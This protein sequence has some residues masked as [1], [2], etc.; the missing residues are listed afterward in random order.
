MQGKITIREIVRK[1]I[2]AWLTGPL[3]INRSADLLP[4]YQIHGTRKQQ[5]M[6]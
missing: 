1:M 6:T 2:E 5:L 4:A 3:S